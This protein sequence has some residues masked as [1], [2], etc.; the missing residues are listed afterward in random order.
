MRGV[1][2]GTSE[3]EEAVVVEEREQLVI[4]RFDLRSSAIASVLVRSPVLSASRRA[5]TLFRGDA[6]GTGRSLLLSCYVKA[7]PP[8]TRPPFLEAS[9]SVRITLCVSRDSQAS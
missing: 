1:E 9:Y 6:V 2:M 8:N 4:P 3:R 5:L 7:G